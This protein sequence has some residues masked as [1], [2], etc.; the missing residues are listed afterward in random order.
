MFFTGSR[1]GLAEGFEATRITIGRAQNCDFRIDGPHEEVGNNH[2]EIIFEDG[3]FFLYDLDTKSGTYINGQRISGR[4]RIFSEDY[5]RFGEH[6]PEVIFRA[7]KPNPGD[8]SVP[9]MHVADAKLTFFSGSDAGKSFPVQSQG[10]AR[11]GRRQE[12]EIGLDTKGDMI[13]SGNHCNICLLYTSDAAD[14]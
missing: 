2:A 6:G 13:V 11:I 10:V 7:G 3:A 14:E 9:E 5:V 8:Q 12:L 1:A 4:A